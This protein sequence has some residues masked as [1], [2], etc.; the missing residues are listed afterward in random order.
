VP[1][2]DRATKDALPAPALVR[3]E[4]NGAP[5]VPPAVSKLRRMTFAA[6]SATDSE[7]VLLPAVM[8]NV[9]VRPPDTAI[10]GAVSD[11]DE[12]RAALTWTAPAFIVTVPV[13]V[14]MARALFV[15]SP[16]RVA[17]REVV[18]VIKGVAMDVDPEIVT[19]DKELTE[20]TF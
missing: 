17:V 1:L 19:A 5:T 20:F 11:V 13:P 6:A 10:T 7:T 4:T 8:V 3:E 14:L 15:A 2:V 16:E 12:V 9:P 18:A